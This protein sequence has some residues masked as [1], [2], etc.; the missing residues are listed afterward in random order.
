VSEEDFSR[1]AAAGR[2]E[3]VN[4]LRN[5]LKITK[6]AISPLT[7]IRPSTLCLAIQGP[8]RLR[9]YPCGSLGSIT[10]GLDVSAVNNKLNI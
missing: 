10:G 4:I 3:F 6:S 2:G 9:A 1:F 5:K 7:A 8:F